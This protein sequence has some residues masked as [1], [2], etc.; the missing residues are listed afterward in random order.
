[1]S[2]LVSSQLNLIGSVWH[3]RATCLR[4]N[5][6]YVATHMCLGD[7]PKKRCAPLSRGGALL[8]SGVYLLRGGNLSHLPLCY[9]DDFLE[10]LERWHPFHLTHVSFPLQVVRPPPWDLHPVSYLTK[11]SLLCQATW[12]FGR[13]NLLLLL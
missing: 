10:F 3:S 12:S 13:N 4:V 8:D 9:C 1:M 7:L 11:Y 2:W 5:L 6:G